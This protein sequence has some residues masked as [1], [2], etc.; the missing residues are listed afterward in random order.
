MKKIKLILIAVAALFSGV[1]MAQKIVCPDVTLEDGVA[2]LVFSIAD[3]TDPT[4][5]LVEFDLKMPEGIS[6]EQEEGE[7]LV[8]K[9][10]ICQ[11]SHGA[12]AQ[13]KEGGFI[14]VLIKND[15]KK[16]FK[17]ANGEVAKIP[18]IADA[19]LADGTYQIQ[20]S[21]VNITANHPDP[22]PNSKTGVIAVQINTETEF[23]INVTKGTTGIKDVNANNANGDGKYYKNGEIIIKKGNR[24]YNTVGAIKK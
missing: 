12:T 24:E 18:I 9:G 1:T 23:T 14:Y 2:E 3:N 11:R 15:T 6:V 20:V 10:T 22:D 5:T 17:Q 13:D 7:Y 21:K 16:E 8:D 19:S 4:A